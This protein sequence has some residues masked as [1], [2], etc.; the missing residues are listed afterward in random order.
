MDAEKQELLYDLE[1]N[2]SARGVYL[3][4]NSVCVSKMAKNNGV[5]Q[6]GFR[7]R[8]KFKPHNIAQI[9]DR[10]LTELEYDKN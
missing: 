6:R 8:L 5:I 1:M 9:V 7:G 4:R 2:L 10:L 3:H